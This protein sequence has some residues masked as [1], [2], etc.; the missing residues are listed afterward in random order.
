MLDLVRLCVL[1][2]V[3][4]LPASVSADAGSVV[5]HLDEVTTYSKEQR[6]RRD[7]PKKQ[8]AATCFKTGE[9][10]SGLNKI[11]Y[12]NCMGSTV[13]ITISSVSL[14]PLSIQR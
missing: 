14:C 6:D 2:T 4:G 5:W 11:C 3:L 7:E 12:Y 8:I 1:L 10:T 9:R 13:A